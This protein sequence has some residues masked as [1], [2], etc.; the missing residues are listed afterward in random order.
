MKTGEFPVGATVTIGELEANPHPLLA[1]LRQHEPV[2][3]IPAF[4][5]WMVTRRDECVDVMRDPETFTVDDP[6]FSTAQVIG[7]SMLSLDGIEHQR[8][9]GPFVDPFQAGEVR[10]RFAEWTRHRA[11]DLVA[12]LAP[13]GMG[14]LRS[15]VA[16]PLSV[17]VMSHILNLREVGA[18]ELLGWYETIVAAVD[19]VTG[20]GE[21]PGSGRAAFENLRT[22]V[23]HN[24]TSSP[25]LTGVQAGGA[26]SADE[27]VSNVAVLLF[28][29]IVTSESTTATV[30]LNVLQDRDALRQIEA[31]R[32]L[33]SNAVEEAMRLEPAAAVVDRYATRPVVLAGTSIERGDLVRV[34]LT[35]A[36]RDPAVFPEPDRFDVH[37]HNAQQHVT[38][39][40]GPHACLGLHLARMEARAAL[41][42]VLDQLG[43]LELDADLSEDVE[44]LIFRAPPAVHAR[45]DRRA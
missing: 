36:N 14:E 26:L 35:A 12:E 30:F 43:G 40:R 45:W 7:P 6:R 17:Q 33:V 28:G 15:S 22:A 11:D 24:L 25:L 5:G 16:A 38:F 37:R 27:I 1:R 41:E 18:G 10:A 3:W 21:V 44:G 34:S 31:D 2:S 20:G 8:H 29:G 4:D 39:A 13:R 32:S 9:R 42:S 23:T 19:A